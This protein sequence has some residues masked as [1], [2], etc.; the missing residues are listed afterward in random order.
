MGTPKKQANTTIGFSLGERVNW[1]SITI[2]EQSHV[3]DWFT[4]KP[5]F[6]ASISPSSSS[7]QAP[8]SNDDQSVHTYCFFFLFDMPTNLEM[9]V[10][11]A[12]IPHEHQ[13]PYLMANHQ[14][15]GWQNSGRINT[16]I[17]LGIVIPIA[18]ETIGILWYNGRS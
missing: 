5:I 10:I 3:V 8:E 16:W 2:F 6:H 14:V 4:R 7:N 12:C 13:T 18:I 17:S 9:H 15:L 11:H 1:E